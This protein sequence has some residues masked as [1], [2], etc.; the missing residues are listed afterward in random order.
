M[1]RL[2]LSVLI[3]MATCV[4]VAISLKC[5]KY[6]STEKDAKVTEVD[7]D[8]SCFKYTDTVEGL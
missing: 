3:M 6:L 8:S 4:S 1:N 2:L 7:C 5:Y